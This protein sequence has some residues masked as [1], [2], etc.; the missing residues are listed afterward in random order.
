MKT[1]EEIEAMSDDELDGLVSQQIRIEKCAACDDDGLTDQ[2]APCTK[3]RGTGRRTILLVTD[4][5]RRRVGTL[6]TVVKKLR[7]VNR[8]RREEEATA[9]PG[10]LLLQECRDCLVGAV[11]RCSFCA[12]PVMP[13]MDRAPCT[14]REMT[15]EIYCSYRG[16]YVGHS[17]ERCS[18]WPECEPFLGELR[19][20][21]QRTELAEPHEL[22]QAILGKAREG[23]TEPFL[24]D[25]QVAHL[26]D[27]DPRKDT[28]PQTMR[29][30]PTVDDAEQW[31]LT[32]DTVSLQIETSLNRGWLVDQL[33]KAHFDHIA[34][35]IPLRPCDG[36]ETE[37]FVRGANDTPLSFCILGVIDRKYQDG[38]NRIV[39]IDVLGQWAREAAALEDIEPQTMGKPPADEAETEG[40]LIKDSRISLP[41]IKDLPPPPPGSGPF[42]TVDET[43]PVH[44]AAQPTERSTTDDKTPDRSAPDTC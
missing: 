27:P 18:H 33:R 4:D 35:Q 21:C 7:Q 38:G 12:P 42:P 28:E 32:K 43:D 40:E 19:A 6:V 30:A 9:E 25:P 3:C 39:S 37:P 36:A 15:G 23:E 24:G 16:I 20:E 29:K 44:P 1:V 5:Y 13:R 2:G 8:E 31:H 17:S 14:E 11:Q 10:T 22:A 34:D 41:P 26:Q